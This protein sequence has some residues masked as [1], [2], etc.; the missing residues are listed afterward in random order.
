[1]FVSEVVAT[2]NHKMK[3]TFSDD[4]VQMNINYSL[5]NEYEKMDKTLLTIAI[6]V[7]C[8]MG[9]YKRA[10]GNIYNSMSRHGFYIGMH[11]HTN[12]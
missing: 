7:S 3:E 9:W 11:T 1:M 2:I 12:Y 10:I 4:E 6:T 8:D 5:N